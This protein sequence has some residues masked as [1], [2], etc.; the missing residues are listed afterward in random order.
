MGSWV[1]PFTACKAAQWLW[2]CL[3]QESYF[4]SILGWKTLYR[5][6]KGGVRGRTASC[7]CRSVFLSEKGA[8]GNSPECTLSALNSY[9][10]SNLNGAKCYQGGNGGEKE[11]GRKY[12]SMQ[13]LMQCINLKMVS[14]TSYSWEMHLNNAKRCQVFERWDAEVAVLDAGVRPF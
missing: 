13:R 4:K 9:V 7:G 5:G 10:Q 11:N 14:E 3:G 6:Q 2:R 12:T 8:G 1:L